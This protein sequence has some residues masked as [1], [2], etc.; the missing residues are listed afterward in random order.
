MRYTIEIDGEAV[1][2]DV[3]A[4]GAGRY[5][6]RVG[7]GEAQTVSARAGAEGVHLLAGD[8]SLEVRTGSG[9]RGDD[10][11][12]HAAGR[13]ASLTVLDDRAARLRAR[14]ASALGG[15]D[16]VVRSPMPGRVVDVLVGEGDVVEAGQGVV[17]VE[18]MKMEN[19][20][21]ASG[22]GVVREV[23]VRPGDAV[24]SGADLVSFGPV[25]G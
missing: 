15:G 20:L 22:P 23:H 5:Q 8:R 2:V 10:L 25:D 11:H 17:I 12:V 21:R 6:V 7:E 18:A 19:E 14:R 4:L 24:E 13:S 9:A 3:S 16:D 1:Q